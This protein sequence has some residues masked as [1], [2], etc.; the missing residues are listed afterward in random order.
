[1]NPLMR[2][3]IERGE[4]QFA[5]VK[6]ATLIVAWAAMV[7]YCKVNRQFVRQACMLGS[8]AYV[9]IWSTWFLAGMLFR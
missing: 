2:V 8:A 3:F 5:A 4:W 1:M 7:W 6:G 9:T